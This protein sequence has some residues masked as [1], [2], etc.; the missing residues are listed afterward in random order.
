MAGR[1]HED[2]LGKGGGCTMISMKEYEKIDLSLERLVLCVVSTTGQGDAPD[3][4]SKFFRF[5]KGRTNATT[6]LAAWRFGVLALGDTNYDQFC[7]PGKVL[8]KRLEEL[9]ARRY[10]T[11]AT[12][13]K[14]EYGGPN[15]AADDAEG[16]QEECIEPWVK[17]LLE[18]LDKTGYT[19]PTAK[20][21]RIDAP[22]VLPGANGSSGGVPSELVLTA[23]ATTS[24]SEKLHMVQDV[25]GAW[26][27]VAG[28][29]G[30]L[31]AKYGLL[32]R[33]TVPNMQLL[34]ADPAL[35]RVESVAKSSSVAPETG[36]GRF[37]AHITAWRY[38]TTPESTE[39]IVIE[40]EFDVS[41][42]PL[43]PFCV[44]LHRPRSPATS[45]CERSYRHSV[46]SDFFEQHSESKLTHQ[47]THTY[48]HIHSP[49]PR[50]SVG[51]WILG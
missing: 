32:P 26:K 47:H 37:S 50:C 14:G 39:R 10:V 5:L 28:N 46:G 9:G 30:L 38:L 3:N 49:A 35:V 48:T 51:I 33:P 34:T 44:S 19:G 24:G 12:G 25:T 17:H 11:G 20:R 29:E 8:D 40:V 43:P 36:E 6:M 4:A 23:P 21:A 13:L 18:T 22:A 2:I 7:K 27:Q 16:G 45:A 31:K 1:I 42:V 15:G 41:Q